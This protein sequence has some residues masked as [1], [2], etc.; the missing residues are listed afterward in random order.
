VLKVLSVN[1][2]IIHR[3]KEGVHLLLHPQKPYW[4]TINNL[5]YETLQL[6]NG[7]MSV[8]EI[9]S[10]ISNRYGR[11]KEEVLTDITLYLEELYRK[12]WFFLQQKE[13]DVHPYLSLKRVHLNLTEACNQHC[14]HCGAITGTK[15]NDELKKEEIFL[16]IDNLVRLGVDSLAMT[17]GEP[18]LRKDLFEILKYA[19][20]R[21]NVVLS[22]N[23]TMITPAD[24]KT[25]RKYKLNIQISLDGSTSDIHDSIRGVGSFVK[26][27]Q[28]IELI[29]EQGIENCHLCVVVMRKNWKDIVSVVSLAREKGIRGIRFLPLQKLGKAREKWED[30]ALS[31]KEYE[32]FYRTLYGEIID[33]FPEIKISTGL[34]GFSLQDTNSGMWCQ[35]GRSLAITSH[36][37]LYPCPLLTENRFYLGN[38]RDRGLDDVVNL[39]KR[40][41]L[42]HDYL[43]RREKM[44]ECRTCDWRGF[45]QGGCPAS[46]Y[47]EKGRDLGV[48]GL[49]QLRDE[50]YESLLFSLSEKRSNIANDGCC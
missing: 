2:P 16:L 46:V 31:P 1:Q 5:G 24:A 50:L 8:E 7:T 10:I 19:S 35:I 26:T 30:L 22:T 29:M 12:G 6:C 45:C 20:D 41:K 43:D 32:E 17:G 33:S 38:I 37:D 47:L 40:E 18:F 49:C 4:L 39:P 28:G 3:Q 34:Q 36:G 42:V 44:D 11:L 25:L 14:L 27:I 15:R 21:L 9:A 48:D 13:G 23:A